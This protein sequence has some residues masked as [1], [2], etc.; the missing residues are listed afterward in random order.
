ML[1]K[2]FQIGHCNQEYDHMSEVIFRNQL[3]KRGVIPYLSSLGNSSKV[4]GMMLIFYYI[5]ASILII[6][7]YIFILFTFIYYTVY[8]HFIDF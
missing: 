5:I 6:K 3:I 8:L 7:L 1:H 2:H 4:I